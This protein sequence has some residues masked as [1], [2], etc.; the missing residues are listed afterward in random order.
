MVGWAIRTNDSINKTNA[1]QVIGKR[2]P[3]NQ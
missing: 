3:D 1:I 2:P